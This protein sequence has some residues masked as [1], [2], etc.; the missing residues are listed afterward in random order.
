[1]ANKKNKAPTY[2]HPET[3][4]ELTAK[5]WAKRLGISHNAFIL[6]RR[7]YGIDNPK[8]FKRGRAY[9]D[10][11]GNAEWHALDDTEASMRPT[12][13][14]KAGTWESIYC[15][16]IKMKIKIIPK[17][18]PSNMEQLVVDAFK[19]YGKQ[20]S[21]KKIAQLM[22]RKPHWVGTVAARAATKGLLE[23]IDVGVYRIV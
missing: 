19:Q 12:P 23:R 14:A 6:R 15:R 11:H 16:K 13:P 21:P 1:M 18:K 20:A 17:G 10:E 7:I 9:S 5:E 4:E 2:R 22:G 8:V 3:G